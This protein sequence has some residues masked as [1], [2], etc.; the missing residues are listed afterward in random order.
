MSRELQDFE[1][2]KEHQMIGFNQVTG[3]LDVITARNRK[4]YDIGSIN[5]DGYVRIRCNNTLYMKHRLVHYLVSG[6][7]PS[8]GHEIDHI[9]KNRSNNA[10]S[11]LRIVSKSQN[12]S[13]CA[14]RKIKH[15]SKDNVIK[16][17]EALANTT[18]SDL[19]IARLVGCSRGTV[20]DIKTRRTRTKTSHQ[21]SWPHRE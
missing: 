1:Y 4:Y 13:G 9:D 11:N 12:N 16:V 7:L 8:K 15:L 19:D 17:C 10:P 14:N 5:A 20:R 18:M 21:Y 6:T 2:F 3:Q